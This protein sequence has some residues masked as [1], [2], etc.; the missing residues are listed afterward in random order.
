[1]ATTNWPSKFCQRGND[2]EIWTV[3]G[4]CVLHDHS[5][6]GGCRGRVAHRC[7]RRVW[8]CPVTERERLAAIRE[9]L[10]EVLRANPVKRP[11][12]HHLALA[13]DLATK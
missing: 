3:E 10:L 12:R 7:S 6:G 1:M 8:V 9:I 5:G 4:C 13:L 11:M 2:N